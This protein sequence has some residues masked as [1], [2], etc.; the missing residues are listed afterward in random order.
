LL[1]HG[2]AH[3]EKSTDNQLAN[4]LIW[5]K[6]EAMQSNDNELHDWATAAVSRLLT[7][8]LMRAEVVLWWW[9]DL[10]DAL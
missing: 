10:G 5:L 8:C 4:R 9:D 7:D 3:S 1:L 2:A 6:N